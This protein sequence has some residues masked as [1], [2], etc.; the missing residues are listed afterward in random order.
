M[1]PPFQVEIAQ[2]IWKNQWYIQLDWWDILFC[3]GGVFNKFYTKKVGHFV[4][5]KITFKILKINAFQYY[6]IAINIRGFI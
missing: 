5:S 1:P 6:G 2:G 4:S 3:L